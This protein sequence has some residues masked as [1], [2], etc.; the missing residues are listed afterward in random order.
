LQ[1]PGGVMVTRSKSNVALR[2]TELVALLTT[3][4]MYPTTFRADLWISWI[5]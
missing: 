5:F 3:L 2:T 4:L 1:L